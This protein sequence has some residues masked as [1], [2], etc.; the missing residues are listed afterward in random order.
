MIWPHDVESQTRL[1]RWNTL[2]FST[3]NVDHR[4]EFA[5]S[6][7]W[8]IIFFSIRNEHVVDTTCSVYSTDIC[9]KYPSICFKSVWSNFTNFFFFQVISYEMIRLESWDN[10]K[11]KLLEIPW[12][13]V[14]GSI[15]R[16]VGFRDWV[17]NWPLQRVSKADIC[18]LLE[19]TRTKLRRRAE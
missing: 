1:P 4:A 7:L 6:S 19:K 15:T 18:P 9:R 13:Y 10:L 12:Y 11:D 8:P 5:R 3:T 16:W 14:G 17:E 2:N